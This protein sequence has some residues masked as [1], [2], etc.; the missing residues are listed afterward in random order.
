MRSLAACRFTTKNPTYRPPSLK[1]SRQKPCPGPRDW[2]LGAVQAI[3]GR[4][5]LVGWSALYSISP[6]PKCV[7]RTS[8]QG[9]DQ[10]KVFLPQDCAR[11]AHHLLVLIVYLAGA[12]R[13]LLVLPL[14]QSAL[15]VLARL[16]HGRVLALVRG[17]LL[18]RGLVRLLAGV[19]VPVRM[20]VEELMHGG[21]GHGCVLRLR[22]W[23][24]R[25]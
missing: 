23:R 7:G 21:A 20:R 9:F 2:H 22:R 10:F 19:G 24:A 18:L 4:R 16:V 15:L 14:R 11:V 5:F 6:D 17:R 25:G 3:R 1:S 8:S 12:Q 13:V